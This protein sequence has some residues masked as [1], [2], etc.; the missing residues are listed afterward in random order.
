[1]IPYADIPRIPIFKLYTG[2]KQVANN[3]KYGKTPVTLQ[4]SFA[5]V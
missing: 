1:M 5:K 4:N 3:R 2:I